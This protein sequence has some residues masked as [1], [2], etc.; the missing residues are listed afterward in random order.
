MMVQVWLLLLFV[1]LFLS[2]S[3]FIALFVGREDPEAVALD[4]RI[5]W[6]DDSDSGIVFTLKHNHPVTTGCVIS[7]VYMCYGCDQGDIAV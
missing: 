4:P 6:N 1:R 5:K 3:N 7:D 2:L